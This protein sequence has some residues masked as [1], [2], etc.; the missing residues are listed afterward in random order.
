[1]I[2]CERVG[3]IREIKSVF[4]N[5]LRAPQLPILVFVSLSNDVSRVEYLPMPYDIEDKL[6]VA[7][8]SSALFDM[9]EADTVFRSKGED[10]YRQYQLD[11][12]HVPF[13]KGVAFP[14]IRRLLNLNQSFP[15]EQPIEGI[16]LSRNDPDTGRRF[17]NSCQHYGLPITR[18]AFLAGKEAFPYMGSFNASLFLSANRDDVT[19]AV[20]AGLPAGLVLPT[21]AKDDEN[22]GELRV[23]FDFDGVLADDEA[24]TIYHETNDLQLFHNAEMERA[25]T[26][27][28]PGLLKTLISKIA[29][30]QQ[31]EMKRSEGNSDYKAAI[32][33]A[34]VTARNAPSHERVV[35]T[36]NQWGLI[37]V[38]GFFL[39]GVE[40]RRVLEVLKPHIFFDDQLQH[41]L[42]AAAAVPSVHIPFGIK[43]RPVPT[44]RELVGELTRQVPTK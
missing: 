8:S 4:N 34:I 16:V 9:R 26:P 31:L 35:T 10:A 6:V 13:D 21:E 37:A 44:A 7:V 29:S 19:R 42:P 20:G 28:N 2:G 25:S 5:A 40:K 32:R 30:L 15:D 14:F 18:G 33:I 1:M 22:D 12:L 27:H 41:L 11:R 17:F 24:E 43:N 23:A 38:E 36:L 3:E 39:G